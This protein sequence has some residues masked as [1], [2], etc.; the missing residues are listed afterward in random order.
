M[1]KKAWDEMRALAEA[2][3]QEGDMP[4]VMSALA[5]GDRVY[6]ASS[7]KGGHGTP[8]FTHLPG[9]EQAVSSPNDF[10]NLATQLSHL[11]VES[12]LTQTLLNCRPLLGI[13]RR[14]R[15]DANC[16]EMMA[17]YLYHQ[18][19]NAPPNPGP[20]QPKAVMVAVGIIDGVVTVWN[21]CSPTSATVVGCR[22]IL[23]GE[24]W[25]RWVRNSGVLPSDSPLDPSS[26]Y[27]LELIPC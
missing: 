27:N 10:S 14:H 22:N 20:D 8:F 17:L 21:A 13:E 6:F 2:A 15:Y 19:R 12:Q 23:A 26:T 3:D 7:I 5:V 4:N 9:M 11:M 1:A 16:G 25:L 18:D 24:S